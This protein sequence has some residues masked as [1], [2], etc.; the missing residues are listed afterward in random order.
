MIPGI[1][2]VDDDHLHTL[3]YERSGW[4]GPDGRIA[5]AQ[6]GFCGLFGNLQLERSPKR[7]NEY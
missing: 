2:R 6:C 4:I 5:N 1:R 7:Q 3:D